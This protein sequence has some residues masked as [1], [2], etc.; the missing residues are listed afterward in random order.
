MPSDELLGGRQPVNVP[1]ET[2]E[3]IIALLNAEAPIE[4]TATEDN[5]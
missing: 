2:R 5:E 1:R 4:G 3:K